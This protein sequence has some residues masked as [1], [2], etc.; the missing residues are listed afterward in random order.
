MARYFRRRY[1]FSFRRRTRTYYRP[2]AYR[3]R[4]SRY[5]KVRRSTPYK[6]AL[7]FHQTQ[8]KKAF[9]YK[10][11][12]LA[13]EYQELAKQAGLANEVSLLHSQQLHGKGFRDHARNI[14]GKLLLHMDSGKGINSSSSRSG[15]DELQAKDFYSNK[16]F[17]SSSSLRQSNCNKEVSGQ[18][19]TVYQEDSQLSGIRVNRSNPR[20]KVGFNGSNRSLEGEWINPNSTSVSQRLH[21]VSHRDGETRDILQS[22]NVQGTK[23]I[24][25]LGT[26]RDRQEPISMEIGSRT[27]SNDAFGTQATS[28]VSGIPRTENTTDRGIHRTD[29]N[30][31]PPEA[32]RQVSPNGTNQRIIG[33]SPMDT[34][35]NLLE[36][37]PP[38]L[39]LRRQP[40]VYQSTRTQTRYS[41]PLP[42]IPEE[43]SSSQV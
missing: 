37:S 10:N 21:E 27:L 13:E 16:E 18:D 42:G 29:S 36:S 6:T 11:R 14:S 2:K 8:A 41:N 39:V 9:E 35:D 34:S 20:H 40:G 3:S 43:D 33:A 30:Y 22:T 28:V 4:F 38:E 19:N 26:N 32:P 15:Q 23:D 25:L 31:D 5:S 17:P 24:G 1:P 7:R 12:T